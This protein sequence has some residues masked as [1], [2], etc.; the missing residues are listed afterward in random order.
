MSAHEARHGLASPPNQYAMLDQANR[1]KAGV[2]IVSHM[3]GVGALF[4]GF[5]RVAAANPGTAACDNSATLSAM[6]P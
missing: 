5:S 1:H 4:Q 6:H 3:E 2:S